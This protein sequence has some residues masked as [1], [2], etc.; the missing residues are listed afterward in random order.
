MALI[1][2]Y[3]LGCI[4]FFISDTFNVQEDIKQ[5]QTFLTTHGIHNYKIRADYLKEQAA[6]EKAA[7][8]SARLLK[9]DDGVLQVY[10]E[11][12]KLIISCYFAITTLSTVGYGDLYPVSPLEMLVTV[13]IQMAGVAFFSYIMGEFIEII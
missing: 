3:F 11:G 8:S 1:I 9:E 12:Q 7:A 13:V 4:N 2:T 5:G 10:N 6:A